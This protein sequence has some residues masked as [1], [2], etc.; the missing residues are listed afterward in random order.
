M[1][2]GPTSISQALASVGGESALADVHADAQRLLNQTDAQLAKQ[3][4]RAKAEENYQRFLALRDQALFHGT[5]FT[6]I[7]EEANL[8]AARKAKI[9][10]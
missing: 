8:V 10:G 3:A 4:E 9:G 2:A 6:G 7:D 1:S 5:L